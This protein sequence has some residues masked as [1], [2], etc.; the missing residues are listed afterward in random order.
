LRKKQKSGYIV[1]E[2]SSFM[3]HVLHEFSPDYTI[4]T[5]FKPDHLDWHR[6]I[7]EYLEAKWH[8]V[9]RTKKLSIIERGILDEARNA[10]LPL[11]TLKIRVFSGDGG[12]RAGNPDERKKDYTDGQIIRISGRKKYTMTD[13]NFSG[14]HNALNILSVGILGS[15]MRIC[16][17][18]TKAYLRDITGLPHRV[19]LV[20]EKEGIRYI[21]DSKSTSCQSLVA[22]LTAF[23]HAKTILIAG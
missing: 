16:S 19:E 14:M 7:H 10:H 22:A 9:E 5:N 4:F 3:A 6:D 13:T 18:R 2:V 15:V 1:V 11:P 21:D 17:K 8:L 23:D 12:A 20:A